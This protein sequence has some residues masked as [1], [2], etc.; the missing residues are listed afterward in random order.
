MRFCLT[1]YLQS[2][3][4]KQ[5]AV[6][7]F[8][9][10]VHNAVC[11]YGYASFVW[12]ARDICCFN[13]DG[14]LFRYLNLLIISNV[15]NVLGQLDCVFAESG[16][17][18]CY[19]GASVFL[20][21]CEGIILIIDRRVIVLLGLGQCDLFIVV[22]QRDT[23]DIPDIVRSCKDV[24]DHDFAFVNIYHAFVF[25]DF[26]SDFFGNDIHQEPLKIL[27]DCC[28]NEVVRFA[29]RSLSLVAVGSLGDALRTLRCVCHAVNCFFRNVVYALP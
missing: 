14:I 26:N 6:G 15:I 22:K 28:C 9:I 16:G 25:I 7:R 1:G 24:N 20:R 18:H 10:A 5:A 8:R 4:V 21:N 12:F 2:D 17:V 27:I 29:E 23:V 3:K 11:R 19:I 13:G